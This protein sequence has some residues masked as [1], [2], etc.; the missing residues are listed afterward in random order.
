MYSVKT[1]I[2]IMEEM[3]RSSN[4]SKVSIEAASKASIEPEQEVDDVL[5]GST[6]W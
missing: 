2:I 4:W 3:S 1:T 5:V 6:S